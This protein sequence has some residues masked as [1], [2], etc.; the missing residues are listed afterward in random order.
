VHEKNGRSWWNGIYGMT[1]LPM[2]KLITLA[3]S[4]NNPPLLDVDDGFQKHG[5]DRGQRA[6][7]LERSK[8]SS[9]DLNI[10]FAASKDSPVYN[11][12][13]VILGWGTSGASLKIDGEGIGQ[14]SKFRV[15]HRHGLEDSDLI[16]WIEHEATAPFELTLCRR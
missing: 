13:L 11:P 4:W 7:V 8:H 16:V 1:D 15:G 9:G 12:A 14:G 6:F 10:K 5:Y 3:R 2:E